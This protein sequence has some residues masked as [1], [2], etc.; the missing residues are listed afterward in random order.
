MITITLW[1]D[2]NDNNE[3]DDDD[4]DVAV[5]SSGSANNSF[6]AHISIEK[7][8]NSVCNY[9]KDVLRINWRHFYGTCPLNG[10]ILIPFL[11]NRR[12]P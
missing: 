1:N 11:K 7:S 6:N 3:Y 8:I 12:T 10:T 5:V 9:I 4:D 2:N